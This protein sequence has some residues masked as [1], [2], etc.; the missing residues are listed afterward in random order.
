VEVEVYSAKVAATGTGD[1]KP[2]SVLGL[3][4]YPMSRQAA[5]RPSVVLSY[6]KREGCSTT[7]RVRFIQMQGD[8]V[9]NKE[10]YVDAS[11]MINAFRHIS[12]S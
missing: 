4:P 10:Y 3:S 5:W 8:N 6:H 9:L 2:D 11:C 12:G 1:E 7:D